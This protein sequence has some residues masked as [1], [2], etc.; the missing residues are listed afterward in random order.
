MNKDIR[1]LRMLFALGAG[2]LSTSELCIL[3]GCSEATLKRAIAAARLLGACIST[4]G[5]GQ[6]PWCYRLG[7]WGTIRPQVSLRMALHGQRL[8][9]PVPARQSFDGQMTLWGV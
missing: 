9:D 6:G 1:M 4:V 7:N 8:S 3:A 2:D 5:G